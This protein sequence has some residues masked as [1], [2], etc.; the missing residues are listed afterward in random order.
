MYVQIRVKDNKKILKFP[1]FYLVNDEIQ[2]KTEQ[3]N[4]KYILH[5]CYCSGF[6]LSQDEQKIQF[7]YFTLF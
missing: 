5:E 3:K 4:S 1:L 2:Q 6:P 7:F